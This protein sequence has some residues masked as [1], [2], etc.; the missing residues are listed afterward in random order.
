MRG[1]SEYGKNGMIG[2]SEIIGT[3]R[4]KEATLSQSK[5]FLH[6]RDTSKVNPLPLNGREATSGRLRLIPSGNPAW[7]V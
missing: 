2:L 7:L 3:M 4:E 5:N 1:I 6:F